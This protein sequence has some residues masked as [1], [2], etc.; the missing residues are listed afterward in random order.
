MKKLLSATV[1]CSATAIAGYLYYQQPEKLLNSAT[2]TSSSSTA[3][4]A[5]LS[6]DDHIHK[7]KHIINCAALM[8][9]HASTQAQG[10]QPGSETFVQISYS[11]GK[12]EAHAIDGGM[13][14]AVV[15]QRY[16]KKTLQYFMLSQQDVD[17]FNTEYETEVGN[18]KQ[19]S[20]S[21]NPE[22]QMQAAFE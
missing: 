8:A 14:T 17:N 11:L 22:T 2:T 13:K 5:N 7:M 15:K 10:L 18:C 1:I 6:Q 12:A 16:D 3:T 20:R 4:A 21:Y 19:E 9:S